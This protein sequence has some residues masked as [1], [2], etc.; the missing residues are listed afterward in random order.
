M[1]P[2]PTFAATLDRLDAATTRLRALAATHDV[3]A[4][5]KPSF[6][7]A[8]LGVEVGQLLREAEPWELGLLARVAP[9]PGARAPLLDAAGAP[10]LALG[11]APVALATPL[12]RRARPAKDTDVEPEDYAHAGVNLLLR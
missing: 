5:P 8:V 6:A 2:P 12:R 1:P 7:R 11:P 10:A 3:P 4:A 9:E